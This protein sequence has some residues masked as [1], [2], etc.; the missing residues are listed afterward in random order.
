MSRRA[1]HP[2]VSLVSPGEE[3]RHLTDLDV[4]PAG[5]TY[6]VDDACEHEH[7]APEAA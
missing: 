5:K 2:P 4:F 6:D 3:L 1:V 7:A